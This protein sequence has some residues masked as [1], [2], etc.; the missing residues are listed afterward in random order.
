MKVIC[1]LGSPRSKGNST[2]MAK[3]FCETAESFGADVTTFALNEL[4][5]RGCQACMICKTELD[6]CVLEDDLTE[7]LDRLH[8]AEIL[9]MATPV[10]YGDVSSQLK[11]FID[12]TYSYLVPD[13]GTNPNPC[14]LSPGKKLV[15]IQ[16]Q[17]HPD[18][19]QFADV[20]PRYDFF[21]KWYGFSDSHLIRACGVFSEGD[22]DSRED[23]MKV[24]EEA[25]KRVMG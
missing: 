24:A 7:I 15:F 14:R 12:R 4:N 8:D 11:G 2:A 1:L 13:Y 10:Y 5:Y 25:A 21:F 3:K 19:S 17:G 16:A 18:E 23:V 20:F 9:V 6:K 22:V